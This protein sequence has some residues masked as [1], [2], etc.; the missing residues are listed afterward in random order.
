MSNEG[1]VLIASLSF[2]LSMSMT[3]FTELAWTVAT[4]WKSADKETKD[5]CLAVARILKERHT[6]MTKV[7]GMGCLSTIKAIS[8]G[9]KEEVKPINADNETKDSE[10]TKFGALCCL[11]TMD[12]VSPG[13]KQ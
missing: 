2:A 3:S 10:L 4:N 5:Y 9:P 1:V 12:S 6:E 7:G 11:L 8:P 13:P